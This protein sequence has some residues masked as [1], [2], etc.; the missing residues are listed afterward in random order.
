MKKKIYVKD[1]MK[2]RPYEQFSNYDKAY[3]K[4][5]NQVLEILLEH[6]YWFKSPRFSNDELKELAI[7]LTSYFEDFISEI[8]IWQ[9]YINFNQ[10]TLGYYL[11]FYTLDEYDSTYLN[12]EDFTFIVWH[13]MSMK[14]DIWYAPD[15]PA[16]ADIGD[17]LYNLLEPLIEKVPTTDFYQDFFRIPEDVNF[18]E[19]KQK[20]SWFALDSYL[21]G[22][23]FS[24]KL[25]AGIE[26]Y[27]E[28][29]PE[30][31]D[32]NTLPYLLY[33]S[34][35]DYIYVKRSQ[36]SAISTVEWF[37]E[38]AICSPGMRQNIA[39][40]YQRVIGLFIYEGEDSSH[41]LFEHLQTE[42]KINLVKQSVSSVANIEP[43]F[44][45][46]LQTVPWQGEWWMTGSLMSM[47][48]VPPKQLEEEKKDLSEVSFHIYTKEQQEM[49]KINIQK[50]EKNFTEFF[51]QHIFFA[52]NQKELNEALSGNN[53]AYNAKH[54][55]GEVTVKR[56]L[57]LKEKYGYSEEN[58]LNA[59]LQLD[60]V[61][62]LAAIFIPGIGIIIEP[63][64]S[65]VIHL[66]NR[67]KIES[68]DE[69]R[70]L[71]DWLIHELHPYT[72]NYVLKHNPTRNLEF[73][74]RISKVDPI[75][76]FDFLKRY[77][78]PQDFAPPIPTTKLFL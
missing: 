53:R 47:G 62:G 6:T 61:D 18:F 24:E 38:V 29:N 46:F 13:Y 4:I 10:K 39:K 11:P 8:G 22:P 68:S 77:H 59:D 23:E 72:A 12:P 19:V 64:L 57:E 7:I 56:R 49:L 14:K 58:L 15:A 34:Q 17:D 60:D 40:L 25:K 5:A 67:E 27:V 69:V 16:L 71:F 74:I 31:A 50:M 65:K 75:K 35:D 37:K 43:G 41:Y 32:S 26:E 2:F 78:M 21:L 28:E 1:W 3:A 42:R 54:G 66:L 30:V 20:L 70:A 33:S 36:L 9:A 45:C 76:S 73:P 52:K 44:V 55:K 63:K 48:A 51:G